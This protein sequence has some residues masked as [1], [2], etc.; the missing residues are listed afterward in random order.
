MYLCVIPFF[1]IFGFLTALENINQRNTIVV[2]DR[3]KEEK[4]LDAIQR[5]KVTNI[6]VVPTILV[7]LS[8]SSILAEYNLTSIQVILCGS[9]PLSKAVEDKISKM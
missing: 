1:H 4:F 2:M 9:A 7:Y 3:F 8:K 5:Y 6:Y